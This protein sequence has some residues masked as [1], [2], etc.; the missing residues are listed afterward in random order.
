MVSKF[1]GNTNVFKD[2]GCFGSPPFVQ[3]MNGLRRNVA[4]QRTNACIKTH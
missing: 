1:L 3:M 2:Y 4:A